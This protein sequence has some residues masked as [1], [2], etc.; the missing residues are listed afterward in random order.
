MSASI[1]KLA[2]AAP[3]AELRVRRTN[4]ERTASTRSKL[5]AATIDS[6]HRHGYAATTTLLISDIAQVSRGAML[7]HFPT[8]IDLVIAAAEHVIHQQSLYYA[9]EL[10]KHK[11]GW[12][13]FVAVTDLTWRA[14]SRPSGI[15]V[16]EIMVAARSDPALGAR[17]RPVAQR[18]E[19][20]QLTEMRKLARLAG[21]RDQVVVDRLALFS[22]ATIRG[23]AVD[24]MLNQDRPKLNPL[25]DMLRDAKS[26]RARK[27]IDA[28]GPGDAKGPADDKGPGKD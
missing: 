17:F 12:E 26:D 21:V 5:I 3:P 2:V 28:K 23:L 11:R 20:S 8:K 14:W 4:A 1:T 19:D 6:L 15:A 18:F 22:L 16:I 13:R 7:H 9:R 24:L 27:V 25:V 10:R